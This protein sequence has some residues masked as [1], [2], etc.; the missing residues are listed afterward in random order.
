MKQPLDNDNAGSLPAGNSAGNGIPQKAAAQDPVPEFDDLVDAYENTLLRYAYRILRVP[1]LAQDVVQEAFLRYFRKPSTDFKGLE[2]CG[3]WLFRVTHN[4]CIDHVKRESRRG[5]IYR[6]LDPARVAMFPL[7][8][9]LS[10]ERWERLERLLCRLSNDQR[11]VMLLY[12]Q[13]KKSYKEI[14]GI[15]GQSLSNVGM[16]L[17]R[18][19]KKLRTLIDEKRSSEF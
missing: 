9:I 17:H 18:G 14:S 12:F 10:V 3:A 2:H 4:L 5:E 7:P 15:T 16:L 1:D 11:A 13:D 6:D 19:L 8:E